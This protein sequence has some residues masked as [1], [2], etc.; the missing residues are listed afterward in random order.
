[1]L[2]TRCWCDARVCR[3]ILSRH[4]KAGWIH[5]P[6]DLPCRRRRDY[7]SLGLIAQVTSP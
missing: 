5:S 1:M 7:A 4:E 6:F 2:K 3:A